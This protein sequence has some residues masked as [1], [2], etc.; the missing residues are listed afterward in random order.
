MSQHDC[1][2]CEG[3]QSL[4]PIPT[5][6]PAGLKGLKYRVGRHASFFETMLA[7]LTASTDAPLAPHDAAPGRSI[8]ST[9]TA[10]DPDDVAIAMLDG[11][12]TIAHVLTFYQE[13]LI[14]ETYLGTAVQ[15]SSVEYLAKQV[16]FEPRQGVSASVLLAFEVDDR[17]PT[18]RIP[19][20]TPAKS[21]PLPGSSDQPQT[22]E[23]SEDFEARSQW[24]KIRPRQTRPQ[25]LTEA[26]LPE[27]DRF[28]FLGN[29]LRLEKYDLL[30][31]ETTRRSPLHVLRILSAEE[32]EDPDQG[33][34]TAVTVVTD[35]KSAKQ[36]IED[37]RKELNQF[38]LADGSFHPKHGA[39]DGTPLFTAA[40]LENFLM[41]VIDDIDANRRSLRV[42][43]A[44]RR[45]QDDLIAALI[46]DELKADVKKQFE[47]W[48]EDATETFSLNNKEY[49]KFREAYLDS[50]EFARVK[51][52][53]FARLE[54]LVDADISV[55]TNFSELVFETKQSLWAA[56]LLQGNTDAIDGFT[57]AG[58]PPQPMDASTPAAICPSPRIK[59]DIDGI[60]QISNL[61]SIKHVHV[62]ADV[63]DGITLSGSPLKPRKL[64]AGENVDDELVNEVK[65]ILATASK[66]G[67][68]RLRFR[69]STKT[70][71]PAASDNDDWIV[72]GN[73]IQPAGQSSP[74]FPSL[75]H[76]QIVVAEPAEETVSKHKYEYATGL[77]LGADADMKLK[78]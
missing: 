1:H 13:R 17:S 25:Q 6:N 52:D 26:A 78:F 16:G 75:I 29:G 76:E 46:L 12:A 5:I 77:K 18:V 23:T 27:L 56:D 66:S 7:Q 68:V 72:I 43:G 44:D 11:W 38:V 10:R 20:G 64:Q 59:I 50:H 32:V 70:A 58:N 65:G 40:Y 47:S 36:L 33:M 48:I 45:I 53:H 19:A 2:S 60:P 22:F 57:F 31:V 67:S 4:T 8:L 14:N 73:A 37:V 61:G 41:P 55:A 15:R 74:V 63:T 28:Y 54:T 35:P 9:L 34:V 24:N 30:V 39:S 49:K 51:L 69:V 21:T 3:I 62:N 42:I 71:L